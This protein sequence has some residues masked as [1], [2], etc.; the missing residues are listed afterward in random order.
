MYR[1][2]HTPSPLNQIRMKEQSPAI[3]LV[4]HRIIFSD[5]NRLSGGDAQHIAGRGYHELNIHNDTSMLPFDLAGHDSVKEFVR[6]HHNHRRSQFAHAVARL[7][8]TST[9]LFIPVK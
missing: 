4:E 9:L 8:A 6:E 1:A 3:H 5:C 7:G 2:V